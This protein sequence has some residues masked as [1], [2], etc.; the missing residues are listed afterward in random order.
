MRRAVEPA[1]LRPVY[2]A[3]AVVVFVLL[4]A[5]GIAGTILHLLDP[6]RTA[7]ATR[8][9]VRTRPSGAVSGTV[10]S[11]GTYGRTAPSGITGSNIGLWSSSV[12]GDS[13]Y[14]GHSY[15]FTGRR[16]QP[17]GRMLDPD[18]CPRAWTTTLRGDG[19]WECVPPTADQLPAVRP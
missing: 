2:G 5:V 15:T 9:V 18:P 4:V 19:W 7:E 10:H 17:N 16:C 13:C 12:V 14:G 11:W 3:A 8:P 6:G 1:M